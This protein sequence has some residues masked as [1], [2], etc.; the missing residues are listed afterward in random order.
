MVSTARQRLIVAAE[1]LYAQRGIAAVSLREISAAAG[2][3]NTA[4]VQYHFGSKQ[5]LIEAVHLHRLHSVNERRLALWEDLEQQGRTADL[6]ALVQAMIE[7]LAESLQAGSYYARF[8]AQ[9]LADPEHSHVMSF[10]FGERDA[11]NLVNT[12]AKSL[13]RG[14]S[15]ELGM[16]RLFFATLMW[17]GALAEHERQLERGQRALPTAA[18]TDELVELVTALLRTPVPPLMQRAMVAR[19]KDRPRRQMRSRRRTSSAGA[20]QE[21]LSRPAQTARGFVRNSQ[22]QNT[23]VR[24]R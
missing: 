13:L 22:N 4:A 21:D 12:R 2:Q 11:M 24:D 1:R 15:P 19:T 18:L 7:P 16:Q 17:V 3:R 8:A 5:R 10:R 20:A 14:V 9:T 23:P 6:R